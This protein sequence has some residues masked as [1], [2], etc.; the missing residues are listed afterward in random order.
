MQLVSLLP[1]TKSAVARPCFSKHTKEDKAFPAPQ[2]RQG[3]TEVLALGENP[4][5]FCATQIQ[6]TPGIEPE[7]QRRKTDNQS[8]F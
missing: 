4:L 1:R 2:Y 8:L 7:V 3:V 5:S 6:N